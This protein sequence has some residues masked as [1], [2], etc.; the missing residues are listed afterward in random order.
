MKRFESFSP[1][2]SIFAQDGFG[3]LSAIL[4][5]FS[6]DINLV[7]LKKFAFDLPK[8]PSQFL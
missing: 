8:K 7:T 3:G 6:P 2:K 5:D 4:L 1:E